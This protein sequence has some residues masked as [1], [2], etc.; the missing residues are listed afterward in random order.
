MPLTLYTYFR[1][2]AAYRVRI[3][4]NMKGVAANE[5]AIH[6]VKGEQKAAGY[7]G[8]NPNATVPTLVLEDG[9]AIG[10]SLAIVEYLDEIVPEPAL[11]PGDARMRA[12][13]R[14][15][16]QVIACDTH[17]L[18][19]TRVINH[20]KSEYGRSQ[21]DAVLWMRHWMARGLSAFQAM[22]PPGGRYCFGDGVTLA[23]LCLVPQMYNARRWGMDLSGL[24]RL[25][26]IEAECLALPAF[27]RARPE[28]QLD[29]E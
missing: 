14:A 28:V 20:L 23:D 9:T 25:L 15:A 11:L 12:L 6:L 8:I 26:A 5:V 16:S 17:P 3:A 24:E 4:L 2:S 22:L 27:D 10:Q 21:D 29:A 19:N 18:N 1:S 7:T 13:I